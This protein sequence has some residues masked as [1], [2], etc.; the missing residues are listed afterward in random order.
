MRNKYANFPAFGRNLK[1]NI[2][3]FLDELCF[4]VELPLIVQLPFIV[5]LSYPIELAPG[6]RKL[7]F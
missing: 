5:Q 3:A 1:K 2:T 4:T 6:K 7:V